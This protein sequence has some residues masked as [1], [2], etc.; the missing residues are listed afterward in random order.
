MLEY[1]KKWLAKPDYIYPEK[2]SKS[3]QVYKHAI[4]YDLK[5]EREGGGGGEG[6]YNN[7][8]PLFH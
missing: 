8:A 4:K 5:S 1:A 2:V 7:V 3:Q 6:V